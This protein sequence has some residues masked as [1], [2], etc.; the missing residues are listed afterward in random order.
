M[1]P[2]VVD[3]S[4]EAELVVLAADEDKAAFL[5]DSP[6]SRVVD[7]AAEV[8]VPQAQLVCGPAKQRL[9]RSWRKV[10]ASQLGCHYV[11]NVRF[12][13]NGTQLNCADGF[14]VQAP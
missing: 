8:C 6:G 2:E 4:A 10:A 14:F 12:V 11:G 3:A 5:G 7:M 9:E 1:F 13:A